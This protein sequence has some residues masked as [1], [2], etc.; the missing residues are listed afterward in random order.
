MTDFT[1][2]LQDPP[3]KIRSDVPDF[4]RIYN[5][6]VGESMTNLMVI[7]G[8]VKTGA[9]LSNKLKTASANPGEV[10]VFV[11]LVVCLI[12]GSGKSFI[13]VRLQLM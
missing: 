10:W 12:G 4:I 1:Y 11:R 2:Y 9:I 8:P 5:L 7:E 3:A 13:F 6:N